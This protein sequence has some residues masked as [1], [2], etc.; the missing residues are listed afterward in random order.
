MGMLT[1]T[2]MDALQK[3]LPQP[4]KMIDVSIKG[5]QAIADDRASAH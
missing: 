1:K 2:E 4:L 5:K 3:W